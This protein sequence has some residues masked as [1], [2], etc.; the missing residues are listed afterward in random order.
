MC[1]KELNMNDNYNYQ[2]GHRGGKKKSSLSTKTYL[3]LV[4]II[5]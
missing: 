2:R 4:N 5:D 3:F 1:I